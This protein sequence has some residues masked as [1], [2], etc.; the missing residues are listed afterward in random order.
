MKERIAVFPGSFDPFTIGHCS[1]I[2]RAIP[3]FDKI[4]IAIGLNDDKRSF[5]SKE[6]R[7][8]WIK[9]IFRDYDMIEVDTFNSLTIEYAK[10]TGA[11]FLL[12]GLRTSADFEFERQIG[13]VNKSLYPEIESI[14]LLTLPEH[15]Y[16]SSTIVRE[17]IKYKGDV[18][19]F[20]PD[21]I[22]SEI[23]HSYL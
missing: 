8:E 16:I 2:K 19:R 14:Y 12:R 17:I 4:I 9:A 20:V 18:S 10:K 7:T 5:F 11:K 3:V 22:A 15:T 13:Q 23:H 1:I 21:I 6:K